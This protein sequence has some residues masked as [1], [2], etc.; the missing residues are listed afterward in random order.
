MCIRDRGAG[1]YDP[2]DN[3]KYSGGDLKGVQRR[4]DYIRE[5]GAT[6]VWITPPVANQWWNPRVRYG[7]YHGYWAEN[8]MQV[9]A[10]AGSLQDYRE[11]SDAL[12]RKG[13]LL[14]TSRCV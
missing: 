11:L 5:L 2:A 6:T 8:L 10:H 14:Y 7:G 4:L 1:E 13:C 3:A 12:H 9:D